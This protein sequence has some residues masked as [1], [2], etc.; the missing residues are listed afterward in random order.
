M[1]D[2]WTFL[3]MPGYG[4]QTA[5]AGRALWHARA[6]MSRVVVEYRA[7]SLLASNFNQLWCSALNRKHGGENIAYFAMLHDDVGPIDCGP[8]KFWLDTLIDELEARQLDVLSVVVPIKDR[9][10]ITSMALRHPTEDWLPYCRLSM[11]DVFQLP[12]TFTA[13]D[14]GGRPLMLNTGCWVAKFNLDWAT[15]AHFSIEDRIVWN[16]ACERYQ[17]QTVPEDWHFSMQCHSLGLK[18]GATRKIPLMHRGDIDYQ[19]M[20]PWGTNAFDCETLKCSPVPDAFPLDVEGWLHQSEGKTLANLARGKRVLEIGSY[21]GRSTICMARTAEHVT[22]VDYFDGR[23]TPN[24]K[25]TLEAF[26]QNIE[27]YGVAEKVTVCNPDNPLSGEY[28]LVFIDGA[29][30]YESVAADIEKARQVLSPHG[31]LAFHDYGLECHPGVKQAVD[32]LG[33]ELISVHETIAVVRPP[34]AILLE[35]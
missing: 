16:T 35:V 14:V 26:R 27:R 15:K 20:A 28:D 12:E 32:E 3:G 18:L 30:D 6:D 2:T 33:G 22:A 10:G 34:A 19:N 13:D 25:G 7:G 11:H 29:H 1:S 8:E 17:S 21:C 4:R 9:R 31:L 5:Q 23:A 24:P